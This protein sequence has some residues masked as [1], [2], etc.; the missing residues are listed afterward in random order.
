[1]RS[2]YTKTDGSGNEELNKSA[3]NFR[4]HEGHEKRNSINPSFDAANDG[5]WFSP[6]VA[7]AGEKIG[8]IKSTVLEIVQAYQQSFV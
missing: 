3:F 5:W 4:P 8:A 7:A 2:F 6:A 1:M